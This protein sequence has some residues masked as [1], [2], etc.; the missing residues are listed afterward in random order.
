MLSHIHVR[1]LTTL[2]Y[3]YINIMA[4]DVKCYQY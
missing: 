4:N 3:S 1:Y 2:I